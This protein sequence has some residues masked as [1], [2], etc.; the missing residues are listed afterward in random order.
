MKLADYL[1]LTG[2]SGADFAKRIGVS[3][4]TIYNYL[5]ASDRPNHAKPHLNNLTKIVKATDGHVQVSDFYPNLEWGDNEKS[6]G[7]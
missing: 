3:K 2:T 6:N 4:Q 1:N 7:Y 5:A